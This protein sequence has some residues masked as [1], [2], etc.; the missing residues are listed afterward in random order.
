MGSAGGCTAGL[1][2]AMIVASMLKA[3]IACTWASCTEAIT[4]QALQQYLVTM[5]DVVTMTC[6]DAEVEAAVARH[7]K[8]HGQQCHL[9][10]SCKPL[11]SQATPICCKHVLRLTTCQS[12]ATLLVGK[13]VSQRNND[14][15]RLNKTCQHLTSMSIHPK[16]PSL[17]ADMHVYLGST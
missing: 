7:H 10:A 6:C 16:S 13:P 9:Q 1:D 11:R 15:G 8:Q 4:L 14:S 5:T 17:G 12:Q 2:L 3:C